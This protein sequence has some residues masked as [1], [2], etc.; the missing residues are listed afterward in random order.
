MLSFGVTISATV[1]Q[2]SE[3][4]EGLMNY[5]V[6]ELQ[7]TTDVMTLKSEVTGK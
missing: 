6:Y 1:P 3:F 4:P 5:S 7:A 2:R